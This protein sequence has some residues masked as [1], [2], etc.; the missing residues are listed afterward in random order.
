MTGWRRWL[1]AVAWSLIDLPAMAAACVGD[2][3][4]LAFLPRAD[5]RDDL[6]TPRGYP[7]YTWAWANRLERRLDAIGFD[8]VSYW[9]RL[10]CGKREGG[11]DHPDTSRWCAFIDWATQSPPNHLTR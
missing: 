6:W 11:N 3:L 8:G 5:Y 4:M 1:Q 7:I 2:M 9:L 10:R